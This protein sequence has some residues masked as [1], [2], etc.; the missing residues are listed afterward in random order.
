MET[1]TGRK[2]KYPREGHRSRLRKRF[3]LGGRAAMEDWEL[4]E[5]LLTYAV[6]RQDVGPLARGLLKRFG[7][8]ATLVHQSPDRILEVPGVGASGATLVTLLQELLVRVLSQR[9]RPGVKI[10]S[11]EDVADY[12]RLAL[13]FCQREK[14]LLLCLS[15]ANRLIRCSCLVEGTVNQAPVY[16]REVAREALSSGATAV[17]LVHNHPGGQCWPSAEDL[18]LTRRMAES[19][20]R[21]DVRLHD[22]LLVAGGQVYSIMAGRILEGADESLESGREG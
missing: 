8:L 18:E 4:L 5:L 10:S 21:V 16:P 9:I 20:Q 15:S 11:P 6:P 3:L 14:V 12:L 7:N 13:G 1:S 22:H 17:I 19:L 2:G